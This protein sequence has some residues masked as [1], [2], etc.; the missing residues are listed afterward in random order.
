MD[1]LNFQHQTIQNLHEEEELA[2]QDQP[3]MPIPIPI[4]HE[5]VVVHANNQD[6][7]ENIQI[8]PL[9]HVARLDDED[10][11]V[12]LELERIEFFQ[13]L[14][15]LHPLRQLD[16]DLISEIYQTLGE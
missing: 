7:A 8:I 13:P 5:D 1:N 16:D 15:Y 3:F 2:V 6:I 4:V 12:L 9:I 14:Q 11:Q 10:F